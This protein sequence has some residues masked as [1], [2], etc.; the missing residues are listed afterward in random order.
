VLSEPEAPPAAAPEQPEGERVNYVANW[1][2]Y[3]VRMSPTQ[4]IEWYRI[5]KSRVDVSALAEAV[6]VVMRQPPK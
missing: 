4:L 1:L 3:L 2:V 6:D 5:I